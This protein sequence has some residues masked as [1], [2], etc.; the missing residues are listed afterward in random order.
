MAN[1]GFERLTDDQLRILLEGIAKT[2][3]GVLGDFC[4]DVYWFFDPSAG[5]LSLE[6]GLATRPVARQHCEPGGAGNVV[7]NM[8]AIGCRKI[9]I[10]G[11][12]GPD[13]W[14]R[15]MQRIL[16]E[17]NVRS[18]GLLVQET[19]WATHAFIKP[20]FN[21]EETNRLDFGNFNRLGKKTADRLLAMLSKRLPDLD[22]VVINEQA[23]CGIHTSEYFREGLARLIRENA[24]KTFIV[25]SRHFSD[26]YPEVFLQ[27][28][29]H[30][31]AALVGAEYPRDA[32]VLAEDV[33]R[34]AKQIFETKGK[35]VTVTRGAR[36]LV[37]C[38]KAG[39]HE[40]PAIQ[41]L[42][43]IDPVGAG[44]SIL[45]ATAL[46]LA[47]GADPEIAATLGNIVAS[48]TVQKLHQTGTA[49]PS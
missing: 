30:E 48:I 8:V 45:A 32:M 21:D 42:G 16:A 23:A 39:L 37:L 28:N 10:F 33:L 26:A 9:E 22:V 24:A 5:E 14:G 2:R 34:A 49:T 44:D 13:P 20:H 40:I 6:T 25:N 29:D 43:K 41:V 31:A 38:D 1:V 17:S 27:I 4:L 18:E 46:A 11:V 3:V 7:N 12:I 19:D 47:A 35:P 36:G 15:E